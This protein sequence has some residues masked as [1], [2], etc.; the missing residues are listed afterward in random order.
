MNCI[1][2]AYALQL[3]GIIVHTLREAAIGLLLILAVIRL[4]KMRTE[5]QFKGG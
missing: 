5:G 1:Y 4:A 2:N 3:K